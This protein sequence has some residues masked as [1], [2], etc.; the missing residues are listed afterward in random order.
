MSKYDRL[1]TFLGAHRGGL[2]L[3]MSFGDI[4]RALGFA[5]P[6]SARKHSAWW[7]NLSDGTH[8]QAVAWL[9]AGWRVWSSNLAHERVEFERINAARS[10]GMGEESPTHFQRDAASARPVDPVTFDRGKLSITARRILDDYTAEFD[11]D[12]QAA[13]DKALHEARIAYRQRLIESIPKE[14]YSPVDSVDLI[15]EDRDAQ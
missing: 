7:T 13:L 12:V 4:E 1:K 10:A 6:A 2:R 5:L 3:T 14:P 15:R 11:G 9:G 8:S